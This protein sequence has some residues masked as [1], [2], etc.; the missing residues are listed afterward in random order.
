MS[1]I[2]NGAGQRTTSKASLVA[3]L[4][5]AGRDPSTIVAERA[6]FRVHEASGLRWLYGG[7]DAIQSVMSLTTPERPLLPATVQLLAA[8]LWRPAP[9]TAL[10][11]GVGGGAIERFVARYLPGLRLC[12]VEHSHDAIALATRH[13][14]LPST[15]ELV[16]ARAEDFVATDARRYDLVWCDLFD[17]ARQAACLGDG[18]FLAALCRR[19]ASQ[20]VLAM[21][22]SPHDEAEL[23][24]TLM[25]LRMALPWVALSAR[26]DGGNVVVMAARQALP[27]D[28]ELLARAARL[29]QGSMPEIAAVAGALVRLPAPADP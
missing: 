11:L 24:H 14:A 18:T 17:G 19:L 16:R 9:A 5:A 27:A 22:L 15:G 13:F 6:G 12:S 4:L 10:N 1:R 28:T 7:G 8:L 23:L 26:S 2:S 3:R 29:A 20:G 21:N 25:H